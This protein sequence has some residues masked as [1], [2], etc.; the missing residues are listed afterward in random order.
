MES[1]VGPFGTLSQSG[2]GSVV[3]VGNGASDVDVVTVV[4]GPRVVTVVVDVEV[5]DVV[6]RLVDVDDVLVVVVGSVVL[7]P[8]VVVV[9]DGVV[10]VLV[11]VVLVL[12]VVAFASTVKRF[13]ESDD[14]A[15]V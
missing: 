13:T 9:V 6:T 15:V 11:D 4:V 2:P 10:V 1:N 7:P 3:V 8:V 12:V 5:E 14:R